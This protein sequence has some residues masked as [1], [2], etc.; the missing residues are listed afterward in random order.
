MAFG[1]SVEGCRRDPSSAGLLG[2]K[3]VVACALVCIAVVA[4]PALAQDELLMRSGTKYRGVFLE[5]TEEEIAFEVHMGDR[6]YPMRFPLAKVQSLTVNGERRDLA[7]G[8]PAAT[9]RATDD[10][11]ASAVAPAAT[12]FAASEPAQAVRPDW[13][14][15]VAVN[16]PTT[17]DLTWA[18]TDGDPQRDLAAYLRTV[19]EPDPARWREG[20]KLLDASIAACEANPAAQKRSMQEIGNLYYRMQDW[21]RAAYWWIRAGV[22][23]TP[24]APH[25]L[26]WCYVRLGARKE[27]RALLAD[28]DSDPTPDFRVLKLCL[29]AGADPQTRKIIES[30][31]GGGDRPMAFLAAG[32]RYAQAG[33]WQAA[34][35]CYEQTLNDRTGDQQEA[36]GWSG[37]TNRARSSL[38]RLFRDIAP[39]DLSRVPDGTYRAACRGFVDLVGVAVRVRGGRIEDVQIVA[40]KENRPRT[41]LDDMPAR[42]VRQQGLA[43]ADT[44]SG[45]TITSNAVLGAVGKALKLAEKE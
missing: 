30:H 1:R 9:P 35:Y 41:A 2:R 31:L 36:T 28:V 15:A 25:G 4:G 10:P 26:A 39:P 37:R 38:V 19:I 34:A 6:K 45:A 18:T 3:A 40:T 44:V 32:D 20:V 23:E 22:K 24:D 7:E 17:L 21:L 12:L 8:A 29:A 5:Q 33:I 42:I 13:W 11:R 16:A 43:G 14:D 27:A